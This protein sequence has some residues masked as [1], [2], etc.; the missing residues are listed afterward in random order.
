[1]RAL[2]TSSWS[3]ATRLPRVTDYT[4]SRP[5]YYVQTG[6]MFENPH[7]V[8]HDE[9]VRMIIENPPEVTAQTVFGKYVESSGLVFTGELI[10]QMIDRTQPRVL[11]NYWM[12]EGADKEAKDW[13]VGNGGFWGMRYHTGIDFGRQTDF[14]VITTLDCWTMPARCVYY[15]RLNRVPWEAIYAEVGKVRTL[16]G[17][18]LLCDSSGPAGDVIMDALSSR[19]YCPTHHKT[20]EQ[21]QRCMRDGQFRTGCPND[22][23]PLSSADG[24]VF[25]SLSK[26]ELIDNL[27]VV[28]SATYDSGD[29]TKDF[30]YV[31]VPPIVQLEEELSF[32]TWDDK[33]LMTD[34]LFS[35]ALACWSGIEEAVG[36]VY[37]GSVYGS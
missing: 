9:I 5:E 13:Y 22:Y 20:L 8:P 36:N 3:A 14:T 2:T 21:G 34:C 32:Y 1:M 28:L 15:K 12:R 31:R 19:V 10:Q 23:I 29:S 35:L 30:G 27:R 18:N 24:Y 16:F 4:V 11:G 25:S 33:R 7:G 26:K 6:S 17:E 37:E